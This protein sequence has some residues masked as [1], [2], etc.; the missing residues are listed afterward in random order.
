[1]LPI[2]KQIAMTMANRHLRRRLS[3]TTPKTMQPVLTE[4]VTNDHDQP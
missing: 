1:M 3:C 4:S 2:K